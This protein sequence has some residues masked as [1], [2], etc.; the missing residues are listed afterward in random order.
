MAGRIL[1]ECPSLTLRTVRGCCSLA[2][3]T[4]SPV[5]APLSGGATFSAG[6]GRSG[7]A[8]FSMSAGPEPGVDWQTLSVEDEALRVAAEVVVGRSDLRD[9]TALGMPRIDT[10]EV[11]FVGDEGDEAGK[12]FQCLHAQ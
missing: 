6:L 10:D 12:G 11:R 5:Q 8:S 3:K 4:V 1:K 9:L 2:L 7:V